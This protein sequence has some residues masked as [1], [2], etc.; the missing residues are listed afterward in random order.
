MEHSRACKDGE[1]TV[2]QPPRMASM[3]VAAASVAAYTHAGA[4]PD[5]LQLAA[6]KD[7]SAGRLPGDPQFGGRGPVR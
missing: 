5:R 6:T 3:Q 2:A 4:L 1:R 7:F